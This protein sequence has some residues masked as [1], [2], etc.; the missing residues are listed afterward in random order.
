MGK[1]LVDEF[2]AK[3]GVGRPCQSFRE[4]MEMVA[5]GGFK[6][7]LG[8]APEVGKWTQ[9]EKECSLVLA[10]NPLAEFAILPAKLAKS[11]FYYSNLICGVVRGALEM[12]MLEVKC[13]FQQDVLRG[14]PG[15]EIKV[16]LEKII[17]EKFHD[18]EA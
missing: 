4:V 16:K 3:Q 18:D 6:M 9:D 2:L 12:L 8:V 7:F 10:E 13:T 5:K 15:T 11:P 1:R 17:E 14:D